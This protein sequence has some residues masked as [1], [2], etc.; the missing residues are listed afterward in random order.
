M[1]DVLDIP[2]SPIGGENPPHEAAWR[3]RIAHAAGGRKNASAV[4]LHFRLQPDRR[5]DLDNLIRPALA[6]LRDAGVFTRGFPGLHGLLATK[7]PSSQ[8]GLLLDLDD[9]RSRQARPPGPPLLSAGSPEVPRD[10]D[11]LSKLHWRDVIAAN[12]AGDPI[13]QA[14][15]IDVAV[16]VTTSLEAVMKPVID[17][18]DP[19]L[20]RDPWGRL[21][22][23][24]NDHLITWLRLVRQPELESSIEITAGLVHTSDAL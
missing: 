13:D 1:N 12:Y 9:T 24:P 10:G 11:R 19:L 18:L 14:V 3:Q 20:G 5:V 22:F 6:G 16:K 8:P 15:W 21:E 2:G 4:G 17:G 7:V 23:T